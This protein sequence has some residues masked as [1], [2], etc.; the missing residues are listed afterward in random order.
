MEYFAQSVLDNAGG[1]DASFYSS[2]DHRIIKPGI[3]P[4]A[5]RVGKIEP[6]KRTESKTGPNPHWGAEVMIHSHTFS[7]CVQQRKDF[8]GPA[9]FCSLPFFKRN[10]RSSSF[11]LDAEC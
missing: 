4:P 8:S 5:A 1:L 9:M 11:C 10:V 6:Q 7:N 2:L 3:V